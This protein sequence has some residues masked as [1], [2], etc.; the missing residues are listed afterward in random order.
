[1][2]FSQ[3]AEQKPLILV[4]DD[5]EAKRYTV[6]HLLKRAGYTV[7]EAD[8]GL[9]G[10]EST[11]SLRPDLVILDINLPDISG[12]DVCRKIR[13]NPEVASVIVL[14]LSAEYVSSADRVQG[15]DEGAD[16][17]ISQPV[18]NE[19][20]LATI[21][22]LLRMRMAEKKAQRLARE[23]EITFNSIE[24]GVLLINQDLS[25]ARYNNAAA[26]F[27]GSDV[28]LVGKN[29]SHFR[30]LLIGD[31]GPDLMAKLQ[32]TLMS[33]EDDFEI[34][35]G[36][37]LHVTIQ[38]VFDASR[39][40][41]GAVCILNDV[42]ERHRA[43][44]ELRKAKKVAE[45]ASEAKTEF[46][47][48]MSHEMRT[49]MNVVFGISNILSRNPALDER[50]QKLV[51]TLQS[52]ADSLLSLINDLLDIAKI[53]ARSVEIE[54][55]P[56][57]LS[58]LMQSVL[59][60]MRI[61]A[62]EKNINLSLRYDLPASG[63]TFVGDS[64]RLGQVLL[65]LIGNAIKFTEA[66]AVTVSVDQEPGSL[67][68]A[69]KDT[70]IG[71]APEFREAIFQKFTQ[72][73]ASI[74]RTHGG[75]GLGLA[76]TKSLVEMMDGSVL[77]D[78]TLGEGSTFTVCLP[79]VPFSGEGQSRERDPADAQQD[80]MRNIGRILL[81]E[82]HPSNVLV[83]TTLLED[84]GFSVDVASDGFEALEKM[85]VEPYDVVLMDVQMP[86]IDGLETT[87]RFRQY[88]E[89]KRSI[90]VP[91]IGMTAHAMDGYKDK[92]LQVGMNDY[93]PKPFNSEDLKSKLHLHINRQPPTA[94]LGLQPR[95]L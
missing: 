75:T 2:A 43:S 10:L 40:F 55:T 89:Q 86:G 54:T 15:L 78:S 29:W 91:I 47:A 21:K 81:V 39:L 31:R 33:Q 76:I 87:R 32:Q 7:K 44:E 60:Q 23:W 14:Q 38:P 52:S 22:A 94:R 95:T 45:Q 64:A 69:I 82:D 17:Y 30:G 34:A 72:G 9:Q 56:F 62:Q 77:V 88:E 36:R 53:E 42:T 57:D 61:R 24:S 19:E 3:M 84:F 90:P 73:D 67:R 66:G 93:I 41:F 48:N 79:L 20:L 63:S 92:C 65:N 11:I 6:V 18:E 5:S 74:N 8:T 4:V 46:L 71:I 85:K 70:G 50:H 1:M 28:S 16:A 49:P 59:N 80:Q 68:I 12:F 51:S 35:S 13:Q 25:I 83:A 58:E 26:R 37:W 27:I